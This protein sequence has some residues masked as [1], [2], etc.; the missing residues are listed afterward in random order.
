LSSTASANVSVWR[1]SVSGTYRSDATTTNQECGEDYRTPVTVTSSETGT[2]KT[3]KATL[4]DVWHMGTKPQLAIHD[5]MKPL[6]LAG[7]KTRT[8]G[9]VQPD[10][11]NG[12]NDPAKEL[13]CGTKNF[14]SLGTLYGT[15]TG[16]KL[17][18][19]VGLNMNGVFN[20]DGG[21]WQRCAL[22]IGQSTIPYWSNPNHPEEGLLASTGMPVAKLF[23]RHMRPFQV[24]GTLA[25]KGTETSGAA[26]S[27]WSY[28][29]D[30]T[31]KLIPVRRG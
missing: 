5:D 26:T 15:P 2:V 27:T 25:R 10:L 17:R 30:F 7:S 21:G 8:S 14:S 1:V 11:P 18:V 12:C 31:L 24:T 20:V 29:F 23:A 3:K 19:S 28:K 6:K 4:F 16:R 13:D 22:G 9:L